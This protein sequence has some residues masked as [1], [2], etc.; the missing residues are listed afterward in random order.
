MPSYREHP[1]TG[2]WILLAPERRTRPNA[3]ARIAESPRTPRS[4]CPFCP[5]NEE[6]TPAPLFVSNEAGAWSLRVVPNKYPAVDPLGNDEHE[7]SATGV[8]EVIIESPDHDLSF[9]NY[10]AGH[11][12]EVFDC[13]VERFRQHSP[14]PRVAFLTLF[15]NEG[16]L[17]G[18]SIDHPHS[19]LLGL[20]TV[21]PLMTWQLSRIATRC[22]LCEIVLHRNELTLHQSESFAI[23]APYASRFPYELWVVPRRHEADIAQ[24]SSNDVAELAESVRRAV[25]AQRKLLGPVSYNWTFR[26]G[27]LGLEP[28]QRARFHWF[29]EITPRLAFLGGF[30][31]GAGMYVNVVDPA[32]AAE[33]LRKEMEP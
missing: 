3:F 9:E 5:G 31:L 18:Q 8:H 27:P 25:A 16:P 10:T 17:A 32:D 14:D 15:R 26:T 20:A 30:E 11:R 12:R 22:P 4:E 1:L 7:S 19:Q 21:P 23:A 29:V 2:E 13:Y 6:E 24:L 33:L 28:S